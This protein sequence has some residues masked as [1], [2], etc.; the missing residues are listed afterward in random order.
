MVK[1]RKTNKKTL[2]CL[3]FQEQD[4]LWGHVKS[5]LLHCWREI[6]QWRQ[7]VCAQVKRRLG[8]VT[9]KKG[10]LVPSQM[11]VTKRSKTKVS[12]DH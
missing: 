12:D 5:L 2:S 4:Q 11:L 1:A 3:S 6:L 8:R 9:G 7:N 10:D